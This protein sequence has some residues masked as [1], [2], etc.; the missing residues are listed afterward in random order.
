MATRKRAKKVEYVNIPIPKPL[1]DRLSEALKNTG[2]R[3]PTE[4]IIFLI[5]KNLPDLE[6]EDV[7]RRLKALG[8]LP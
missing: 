8:Y 1:Y 7:K 3:S 5:R 4:Y 2:Y 6:S